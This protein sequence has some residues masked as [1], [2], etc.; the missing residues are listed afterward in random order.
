[1]HNEPTSD[2]TL[3]AEREKI[4]SALRDLRG[5][6]GAKHPLVIGNKP[7]ATTEWQPSL[8][9][10]NQTEVIGYAA[11]ADISHAEVALAAAR[12][13]QPKWGRTSAEERA[14]LLEKVAELMHRQRASLVALEI[15][16][17][18]KNWSEADADVVEAID[19]C[20]F[21]AAVMRNLSRPHLTQSV[22]GETNVQLWWPRGVGIVI[23]P[24][25]FPLA[26]LTGMTA[27]AVV[28]GNAVLMKPSDQTPII[29]SR[30]MGLFLEAGVPPGVLN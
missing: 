2:F 9:P 27:A 30:L 13:A 18:G 12:A 14:A 11:Q 28:S 6:L 7:V 26:I 24:W 19:F 3:E 20:R 4:S 1:F 8:N 29:A 23:A 16:E 10:V 22:P 15:L 17:A 21:Y 5:R 25:N